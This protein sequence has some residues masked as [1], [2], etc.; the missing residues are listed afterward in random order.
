M[1]INHNK[2]KVLATQFNL[3]LVL[4]FGSQAKGNTHTE[5]DVDIAFFSFS[6]VDEEKLRKELMHLFHRAD[7]D[8]VNIYK[9]QN[10][11]L[12]Y[13][14]L[15]TGKV[16][17]ESNKG[18]KSKLEWQSYFDYVDFKKYYDSQSEVLDQKIAVM[19]G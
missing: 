13:Q 12:R 11:L 16:L 9:C 7:I 10:H 19:V 4:L 6:V 3:S 5:S 18:L 14:I 1:K 15:S 8:I 17:Y 2:I